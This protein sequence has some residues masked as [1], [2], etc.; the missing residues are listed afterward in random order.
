MKDPKIISIAAI[1]CSLLL[2]MVLLVP[3]SARG[4]WQKLNPPPDVDK[5]EHHGYASTNTCYLAVAANMLAGLG[6]GGGNDVQEPADDIYD[7]LV[8]HYGTQN[9]GWADTAMIWWLGSPNN[10]WR[11]SKSLQNSKSLWRAEL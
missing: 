2:F 7:E 6:Y 8:D 10:T 1:Q 3:G 4:D 11:Q 9:A 5:F